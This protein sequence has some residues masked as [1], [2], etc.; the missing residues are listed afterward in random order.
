MTVIKRQP[1]K[2][3]WIKWQLP[4]EQNDIQQNDNQQKDIVQFF[5]KLQHWAEE[6]KKFAN[7]FPQVLF[8]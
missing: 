1:L 6:Y 2:W 7:P 4:K 8:S 3:N 5:Y